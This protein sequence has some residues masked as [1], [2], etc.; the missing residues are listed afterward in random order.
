MNQITKSIIIF[1]SHLSF[2]AHAEAPIE[3]LKIDPQNITISGLSS[4][5]YMAGQYHLAHAEAIRGVGIL[6]AGP[7]LCAQGSLS[8]A[9]S[10]CL[11]KEDETINLAVLQETIRFYQNKKLLA[12]DEKIKDSQVWIYHG[13]ADSTVGRHA[14]QKLIEQYQYWFDKEHIQTIL[15][16]PSGHHF[17]TSNNGSACEVSA[18]PYIGACDFD[19]AGVMLT[20]FYNQLNPPSQLPEGKVY[21]IDQHKLG[22]DTAKGLASKGFLYIPDTC[23]DGAACQLHLSFHGCKQNVNT[24]GMDY[25]EQ[26]G[27]NRWA[28]TNRLVVL[29]PQTTNSYA[30]PFNPHG[31]WDWWGY[32]DADYATRNG[33][34]IRAVHSIVKALGHGYPDSKKH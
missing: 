32:T 5:G 19:A 34:Q 16:K 20:H 18:P 1:A 25:I 23:L 27:F 6:A 31:C 12:A 4:G 14:V 29:Y 13:E 2:F 22:G 28:D 30:L 9:L 21:S 33:Q 17:P 7:Y 3:K 15:N 8:R 10:A 26:T 11:N 24:I